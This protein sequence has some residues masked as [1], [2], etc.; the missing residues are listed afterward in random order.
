MSKLSSANFSATAVDILP[1]TIKHFDQ[2][3]QLAN[4]VHGAG[5][6]DNE[7]L[8]VM[9]QQGIYQG[10]NASFVAL[11]AQQVLGYRLSFAAGQWQP[12]EWCSCERWPVAVS[13]MAYFKSVAVSPKL[14][15][16]GIGQRLLQQS[17]LVL[18]QQGA[19]AG[20]AH[21]WRESPHNSAVRYFSKAGGELLKIHA[22][23]WQ[24]L[25][26]QGYACPVCE[27]ICCCSAA[28]MVIVF[29]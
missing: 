24:A 6:M 14:Q 12:D 10:L 17:S 26:Y 9:Q 11:A 18:K 16:Q 3:T 23:R 19:R 25:S 22:N 28:E 27:G 4:E 7:K 15:G 13:T 21:L 2:V 8:A 1:L 29:K 20:L 5:Y